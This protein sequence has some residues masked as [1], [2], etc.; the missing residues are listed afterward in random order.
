LYGLSVDQVLKL[1]APKLNEFELCGENNG[2]ANGRN[3]VHLDSVMRKG[4][5]RMFNP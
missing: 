2:S 5:W 3:W 1:I 4:Q